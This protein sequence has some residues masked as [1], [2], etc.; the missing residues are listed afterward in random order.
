M[1]DRAE[2]QL[3]EAYTRAVSVTPFRLIIRPSV[4]GVTYSSRF[5]HLFIHDFSSTVV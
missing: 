1:R 2:E 3:N 4:Q 5:V